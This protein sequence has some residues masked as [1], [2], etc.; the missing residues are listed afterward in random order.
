MAMSE[1]QADTAPALGK[2]GRWDLTEL[3]GA[4]L[5]VSHTRDPQTALPWGQSVGRE[6]GSGQRVPVRPPGIG[7]APL[8][9]APEQ[10][11]TPGA[12]NSP[13]G[14]LVRE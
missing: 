13:Q 2:A 8:G 14:D 5:P 1:I 11:A 7:T 4:L 10:G 6:V 9:C 3:G 12:G